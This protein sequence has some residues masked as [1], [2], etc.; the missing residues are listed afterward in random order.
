MYS[1]QRTSIAGWLLPLF[2]PIANR[3]IE[4]SNKAVKCRSRPSVSSIP[5][6][7][8]ICPVS[9]FDLAHP[10]LTQP[11]LDCLVSR[12]PVCRNIIASSR[13]VCCTCVSSPKNPSDNGERSGTCNSGCLDNGGF[14]SL[15][16]IDGLWVKGDKVG[17]FTPRRWSLLARL[18]TLILSLPGRLKHHTTLNKSPQHLEQV[19]IR[20]SA[21]KRIFPRFSQKQF[22]SPEACWMQC[23]PESTKSKLYLPKANGARKVNPTAHHPSA[24]R[25]FPPWKSHQGNDGTTST[26]VGRFLWG[27]RIVT[28]DQDIKFSI[29]GRNTARN[30]NSEIGSPHHKLQRWA[31]P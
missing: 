19:R 21:M 1:V 6:S 12:P 30:H 3:A 27:T 25:T 15:A 10:L 20:R 28:N 13:F 26:L 17:N 29:A 23:P 8:L 2:R 31:I 7:R 14:L 5:S 16:I 11:P 22:R 9:K 4:D 18:H 24:R